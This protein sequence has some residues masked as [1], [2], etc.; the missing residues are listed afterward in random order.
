M[1]SDYGVKV[2]KLLIYKG[3]ILAFVDARISGFSGFSTLIL[4]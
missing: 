2:A 4:G 1:V 3:F